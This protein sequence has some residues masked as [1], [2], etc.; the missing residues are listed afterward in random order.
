MSDKQLQL[1]GEKASGARLYK[2]AAKSARLYPRIYYGGLLLVV[3]GLSWVA[4]LL[5]LR[6]QLRVNLPQAGQVAEQDYLSPGSLVFASQVLTEQKRV[7]AENSV[8]LIYTTP[9]TNVARRQSEALR[10]ALAYINSVRADTYATPTQKL[11]DLAAMDDLNLS[12]QSAL[13]ILALSDARWQAVSQEASVAMERIMSSIIRPDDLADA[14]GRVPRQVSLALSE[15]E[16]ELTAELA[17]AFV[18]P[19]TFFSQELTQTARQAARDAVDP[20][21]RAYVAGQTV[22]RRGQVLS[23]LDVEALHELGLIKTPVRWHEL[24][25]AAALV[26][27]MVIFILLY[28]RR[29][30]SL[31][32]QPRRLTLIAFVFLMFLYTARLLIPFHAV[33]PYAFPLAAYSMTVVALF[34]SQLAMITTLPLAVMTAFGLSNSLDLTLYYLIASLLGVLALGQARRVASFFWAGVV[35]AVAGA[36]VVVAYRIAQPGMD[37]L[38]ISTLSGVSMLNGLAT[39]SL[40]I[41]LQV[42]LAQLLGTTTPMQLMDLTRPDHPLLQKLLHE[43]AGTYQHSLQV[44]NLAEQAAERIGAD[45]LLTRVGALYHDA[46]KLTNP[47][48]FIENQAPGGV[49]PHDSLKPEVSARAIIQH[50]PDGLG[51]ARKYHL[52]KRVLDFI[53][54]HHGTTITRYQYV[55]A[56]K[57]AGGDE[58]R[59]DKEEFRYPGPRPQTRETA[60]LMLADG[61]EARV[62]AERPREEDDLRLLIK[63]VIDERVSSGELDDTP[64]TLQDLNVILDSFSATLRGVYHPRIVYPILEVPTSSE[65]TTRPTTRLSDHMKSEIS[66]AT[67][68]EPPNPTP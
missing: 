56:V 20:L 25:S 55:K 11:E 68:S 52:P 39:A 59:V 34:G 32:S 4:L 16:A 1:K 67:R 44:A 19:N 22:V 14:R 28:F 45:P 41:L 2:K 49:N 18:A 15:A 62:R 42:V 66:A 31:L 40:T 64:M 17:A 63:A 27:V 60:I 9:D 50:V 54:E 29:D 5:P 48:F 23:D 57:A 12:Q 43:A 37:W 35:V 21:S 53:A 47:I 8:P 65:L 24:V 61:C 46:G 58:R 3:A 51:L 38:G 10:A 36:L 26:L 33:I 30:R 7:D 6:N 13:D